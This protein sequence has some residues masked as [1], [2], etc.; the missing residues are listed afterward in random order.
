VK[1]ANIKGLPVQQAFLSLPLY[2]YFLNPFQFGAGFSFLRALGTNLHVFVPILPLDSLP[3][4]DICF[5][6]L[7]LYN[8][9]TQF[10]PG[11]PKIM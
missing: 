8:L 9:Q 7:A 2:D 5:H 10:F 4:L 1:L 3:I 6:Y 11:R